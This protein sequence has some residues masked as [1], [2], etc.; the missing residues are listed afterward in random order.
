MSA[1]DKQRNSL[2]QMHKKYT[3]LGAIPVPLPFAGSSQVCYQASDQ[4]ELGAFAQMGVNSLKPQQA[5]F[6]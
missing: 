4:A 5:G 3:S 6:A 2:S 1:V